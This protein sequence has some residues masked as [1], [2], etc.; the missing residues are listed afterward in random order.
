M[1]KIAVHCN[2]APNTVVW[3]DFGQRERD[4]LLVLC[5][6]QKKELVELEQDTSFQARASEVKGGYIVKINYEPKVV[7]GG[8][9]ESNLSLSNRWVATKKIEV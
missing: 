2:R 8:S 4:R 5:Y 6:H 3:V 7:V 9:P 1:S